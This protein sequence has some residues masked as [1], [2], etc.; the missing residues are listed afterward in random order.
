MARP[1]NECIK[2]ICI[3]Q[4]PGRN[5]VNIT[6]ASIGVRYRHF[7][8]DFGW[9]ISVRRRSMNYSKRFRVKPGGR[10]KLADFDPGFR[11]K[12]EGESAAKA[13][14]AEYQEKLRVLQYLMYAESQ[15]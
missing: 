13:E 4:D 7:D 10:V 8:L 2:R 5:R 3:R 6:V 14:T 12:H 11:D 1:S 9:P 15:R